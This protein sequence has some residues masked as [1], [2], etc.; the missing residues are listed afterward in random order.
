MIGQVISHYRIVEKLGGGNMGVVYKAEDLTLN[1]FVALKFLPDDVT[2]DPLVLARFKREARSASALNHP[3]ICTIHEIGEQDGAPFIV[4]E[5]LDGL[6]LKQMILSE[7]LE[8]SALLGF[9]IEIADAL[10][11][12]HTS[13]I[14]HRDI[15]SANILVTSRGHAKLLDFGLAKLLSDAVEVTEAANLDESTTSLDERHLTNAH[16][17]VGT[18]AYMSPE[19]ASAEKL[20]SR[21]DLFSFGVVLYEMATGRLP[22]R[23]DSYRAMFKAILDSVPTSA[24]RLNPNV[25][26]EL[27][28]IINKALEKERGLRYQHAA[29]MKADL[30]RLKRD[31]EAR[32]TPSS[33][34]VN[35]L[36]S[37]SIDPDQSAVTPLRTKY[38]WSALAVLLVLM[39]ALW[40]MWREHSRPQ[41]STVASHKTL[42]ERQ[43]THN[44]PEDRLI[45]AALS[46]DGSYLAYIDVKGL[47][48]EGSETGETHD[49]PLPKDLQSRLWDVTW[50]PNGGKL[51]L[52][53]SSDTGVQMTWV[54]SVYGGSPR[55]L[56]SDSASP[57]VSPDGKLIAFVA[58]G[59]HEL[60]VM[61]IDGDASH[62]VL[63]SDSDKFASPAWSPAGS[64]LA[65]IVSRGDPAVSTVETVSLNGGPPSVIGLDPYQEPT[66]LW[67][68]DG[69]MIFGRS[70]GAYLNS[71]TNLWAIQTDPQTGKPSG[72]AVKLTDSSGFVPYSA[73]LSADG[74][75]LAVVKMHLQDDVYVGELKAGGTRLDSPMRITVSDS[76][77]YPSGWLDDEKTIL[78]WSNRT[79][80]HQIFRQQLHQDTAEALMQSANDENGAELS[81]D[82]QWILYW[83]DPPSQ[84]PQLATQLMRL[85]VAGGTPEKVLEAAEIVTTDFHCSAA[86]A[87]LCAISRWEKNQLSF[88]ALDP[89]QGQG[90]KLATTF[91]EPPTSLTW[92]LSRDGSKIAIASQDQLSNKIR[93]LDLSAGTANDLLLPRGWKVW[94]L[95]WAVDGRGL[96]AAAQ[97]QD[98]GYILAN[99]GLDGTTHT[100][101]DRGRSQWLSYICP[102]PHGRYL[103]FSQRTSDSNAWL[104][105]NF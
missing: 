15:K 73:T 47:H 12:A 31:L 36:S 82:G 8:I 100:L 23:G 32:R 76:M 37:Q 43:V 75:R 58:N 53:T 84:A 40:I 55:L 101:L 17:I 89:I 3:G 72:P 87:T 66:L 30:Q 13:G 97:T 28:Q 34:H 50:F 98:T 19:Q 46:P 80:R 22:F 25:P 7:T 27:E 60:W 16:S 93:I 5:F 86:P 10:E 95:S 45:A 102:S 94:S 91:M 85:P 67:A 64:R 69:R 88:Y 56:R 63:G 77:D 74:K 59:A 39:V 65:Y 57:S 51:I 83:S 68:P 35:R 103:A 90:K 24:V 54:T 11:A 29:E 44:A 49:V 2:D 4:M 79:G 81:A 61:G 1:R 104:L 6:T 14:I 26:L 9:A 18:A 62:K 38:G 20:D 70:E 33:E 41:T 105:Q 71:G 78:F 48:L 96:L 99:I 42:S 21:T 92:T 52:S